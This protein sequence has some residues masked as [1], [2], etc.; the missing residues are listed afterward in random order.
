MISS[1]GNRGRSA[2]ARRQKPLKS[3]QKKTG[4]HVDV[5]GRDDAKLRTSTLFSSNRSGAAPLAG[6]RR[7]LECDTLHARPPL[8]RHATTRSFVAIVCSVVAFHAPRSRVPYRSVSGHPHPDPS[9]L[10]AS[11]PAQGAI[12]IVSTTSDARERRCC[13]SSALWRRRRDQDTRGFAHASAAPFAPFPAQ[14]SA[15]TRDGS[16]DFVGHVARGA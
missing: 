2:T 14:Q 8:A 11:F 7:L 13:G 1:K 5:K 3:A 10:C 12:F 15:P 16:H 6:D 9:V 4:H